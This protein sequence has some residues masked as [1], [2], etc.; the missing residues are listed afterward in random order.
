MEYFDCE[1]ADVREEA[2]DVEAF[3]SLLRGKRVVLDAVHRLANPLEL[4]KIAAD[5]YPDATRL[6]PGASTAPCGRT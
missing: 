4:L 3:L 1:R 5:Y 2:R 6:A